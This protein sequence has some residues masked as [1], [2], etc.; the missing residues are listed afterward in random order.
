MGTVRKLQP[1][2][3]FEVGTASIYMKAE[4]R[5]GRPVTQI[6][7]PFGFPAAPMAEWARPPHLLL[8]KAPFP[9]QAKGVIECFVV[10]RFSL[11]HQ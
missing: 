3:F 6:I 8:F 1:I 9:I 7:G 4:R 2:Y 5:V 10:P 11:G